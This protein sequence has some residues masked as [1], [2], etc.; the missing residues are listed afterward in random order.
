M[1]LIT[2]FDVSKE[3]LLSLLRDVKQGKIQLPDFQRSWVWSD[4]QVKRLLCNVS[5]AYPIGSVMLLQLDS[6]RT[7]FKPR[8]L[9]GV[10]LDRSPSPTLLILDGQQRLTTLFQTL[11]SQQ[12]VLAKNTHTQRVTRRWYYINIRKA[13]NYPNTDR[14]DAILG[15]PE[16][17]ILR[18]STGQIFD[19]SSLEKE[20]EAEVFPLS[21]IFDFSEWRGHYSRYWRYDPA[22]LEMLDCFE[23]KI[24]KHFEHYQVPLIQLRPELSKE[25][26]C[27]VFEDVNTTGKALTCFD[28]MTASYATNDFS[29]REDWMQRE[30]QLQ[31]RPLL[32]QVSSSDFLRA[33]TLVATYLRQIQAW[34]EGNDYDRLVPVGCS[35]RD[36]LGLSLDEYQF[37]ADLVTQGFE[38]AARLLHS[39]KFFDSHDLPYSLQLITLA[40]LCTILG[41]QTGLDHVRS[42]LI[43]WFWCGI[44][45]ELYAGMPTSRASRDLIE[46]PDWIDGGELPFTLSETYFPLTRLFTANR[47]SSATYKGLSALILLNGALDFCTGEA[48]TDG[49]YFQAQIDSHH[50]FPK[51]WC[52][53]KGIDAR[54]YNCIVNRTPISATTNRELGGR[55]PSIYLARLEQAGISRERLDEILRSHFIEPEKLRADDF[56]SFF[57][58]RAQMLITLICESTSKS[59]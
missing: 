24:V 13:L 40:A 45:G 44:F 52:Q 30:K 50:I 19:Y 51:A 39:Q 16:N 22:K 1:N 32:K 2:T 58:S 8:L 54:R 35:H 31:R 5:L 11:L 42:K 55:A 7:Y 53:S 33:V 56:D 41:K 27:Q 29:L 4:E 26:I 57:N 37:W 43:R 17:R 9:E 18:T 25:A 10:I 20:F 59:I 36:I 48:I 46:V 12:P 23:S 49:K 3:A 34:Q 21:H 14:L 47:R 28:L 38:E 6:S 15:L